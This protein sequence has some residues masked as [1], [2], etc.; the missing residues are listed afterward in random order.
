MAWLNIST[1]VRKNDLR[2]KI[3][4]KTNLLKR[5][6]KRIGGMSQHQA[7]LPIGQ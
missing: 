1:E 4:E 5:W 3:S 7:E 2:S 6:W